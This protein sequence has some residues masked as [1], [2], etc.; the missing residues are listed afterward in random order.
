MG[1]ESEST[2]NTEKVLDDMESMKDFDHMQR[3]KQ[4]M[5]ADKQLPKE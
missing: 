5:I 1:P 2:K 3:S 4:T